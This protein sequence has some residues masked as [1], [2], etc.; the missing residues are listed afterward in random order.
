MTLQDL[1]V[2]ICGLNYSPEPTGNAPY[3]TKL[4]EG[5]QAK[6]HDVTVITGYP[7]YP[8]WKILKGYSGLTMQEVINGVRVQR[9]RHTVPT[10]PRGFN[11]LLMELTF[12]LH[13]A[14]RPWGPTDVVLLVSPGLF[15]CGLTVIRARLARKPVAIWVQDLYSRGLEE[16]AGRK[17]IVT[18]IMKW[19]EA[20]ILSSCTHVSVIHERFRQYVVNELHLPASKVGVIRNWTHIRKHQ[21]SNRAQV[22]ERL[23][24]AANEI[25]AL[26][27]GNMGVKQGLENVVEAARL[28]DEDQHDVRFVLLGDGNRRQALE[29]SAR[30]VASLTFMEPLDDVSYA[31]ALHSADVLIVNELPG[32][33]EMSVPSKLTSY[34]V[35]GLPVVAA[36]H[37]ASATAD[38]IK[39]SGGG[40]RVEPG[41]PAA[42]LTAIEQLADSSEAQTYGTS[43]RDYAA[44]VLSEDTALTAY[45]SLLKQLAK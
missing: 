32:V 40:I 4:A 29:D 1:R 38:E 42:L 15:A 28:A 18:K 39:A 7:H 8:Q 35:T 23:G 9:L 25:I 24:W 37:E 13:T 21:A 16:T 30:N 36:T 20:G 17:S 27:A 41:E 2:T 33:R 14:M 10:R 34:F 26:H 43:G 11:R 45:S 19:F 3:T 44:H 12:G 22:R 6:G 5:L 31:E